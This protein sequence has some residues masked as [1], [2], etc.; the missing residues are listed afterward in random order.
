MYQDLIV[1]LIK[2]ILFIPLALFLPGYLTRLWLVVPSVSVLSF[3]EFDRRGSQLDDDWL[4]VLF[5]SAFASALLTGWLGCILAEI[6][7]LSLPLLLG[8]DTLYVVLLGLALW[9]RGGPWR[10]SVARP[11]LVTWHL[12]IVLLLG[13]ILSFRPHEMILGGS[14]AGVYVNLG[15]SIAKSGSLLIRDPDLAELSSSLYSV[16]FR[17]QPPYA[18]ARY[19]LLPGFYLSNDQPSSIGVRRLVTCC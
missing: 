17:E 19:S 6:G 16:L 9:R 7:L 14:D 5:S 1:F 2:L 8:L 12:V 3:V 4:N 13:V 10:V 15:A 18:E 11:G